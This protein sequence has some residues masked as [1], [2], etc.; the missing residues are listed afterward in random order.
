MHKHFGIAPHSPHLGGG[1]FGNTCFVK[2]IFGG[3]TKHEAPRP[4]MLA[5]NAQL[6]LSGSSY[7]YG[8][9]FPFSI[10]FGANARRPDD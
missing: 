3:L 1:V 2:H 8:E 6:S 5:R 7:T 10:V 4:D 9:L